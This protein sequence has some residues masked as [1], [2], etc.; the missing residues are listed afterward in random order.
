MEIKVYSRID[1]AYL[2]KAKSDTIS[3]EDTGNS[4]TAFSFSQ[5][6]EAAQT[7]IALDEAIADAKRSGADGLSVYSAKAWELG[8][9][10]TMPTA[11]SSTNSAASSSPIT[12]QTD[13][14]VYSTSATEHSASEYTDRLT[15]SDELNSYFDEASS[16]YNVDV[17][18][19]KAVA[20]AESNYKADAV[21]SAGAVGIM[22]LMPDTAKGLGVDD[23]Y[24]AYKNV[25]GGARYLSQL[26]MR[27]DGN[28][29]L[30]LAA[31]NAGGSNVD[32]YNGIPPFTE[33][34]NYVAKVID[35][36]TN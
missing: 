22:Q 15:C 36:Y 11:T 16:A 4:N 29:A 18:L 20:K 12:Y 1:P 30:A 21:S 3:S 17:K 33:T 24:N 2:E 23:S 19:L 14:Q 31:Y 35:Y 26:L 5:A 25:M 34:Q 9:G 8:V 32:K 28:V 7:A 13:Y 6:M 10:R 27:Y